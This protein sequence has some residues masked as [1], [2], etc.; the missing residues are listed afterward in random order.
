MLLAMPRSATQNAVEDAAATVPAT[1]SACIPAD[2]SDSD[3]EMTD[4]TIVPGTQVNYH[5][6]ATPY[7]TINARS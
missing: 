6:V 4:G 7:D 1:N 3:E 5:L 2:S